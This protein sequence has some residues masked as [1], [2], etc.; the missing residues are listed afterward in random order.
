MKREI[1]SQQ[2]PRPIGPY[3]QAVGFGSL[4]FFSGQI[5]AD[6]QTNKMLS[7]DVE[8]QIRQVFKNIE[9]LLKQDNLTKQQVLKVS[10]FLK[11]MND[12]VLVNKHYQ[13]FFSQVKIY[14]ARETVE[15]SQ[16]PLNAHIEI[17]LIAG[18][19]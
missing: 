18:K 9:A 7:E 10:I 14:P 12:F 1:I 16:L 17:S 13:D 8:D 4:V 5:G 15:V 11:D 2:A 19:Q 6:P 3:S